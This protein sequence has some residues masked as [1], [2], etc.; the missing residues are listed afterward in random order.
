ADFYLCGP[1]AFLAELTA[2]LQ[3][4]G[5]PDS[6]I[7]SEIFGAGPPITPGIASTLAK[8]PHQPDGIPGTGPNVS[9]TRS[10]LSAP[11]DPRFQTLL[12]FAEA[13]DIPVRWACRTGVCHM[14]ESG[15]IDGSVRYNPE[16][17]DRPGQGSV[18][19][20]CSTPFSE[21]ELDL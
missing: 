12:E 21:I 19:I 14:C 17:L 16:P 13:C 2:G 15:L 6:R 4:W 7:H 1:A 18:L 9:F 3:S 11:W 10:G 20:C 8:A 5:V